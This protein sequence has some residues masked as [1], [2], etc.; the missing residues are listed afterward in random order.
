MCDLF[1]HNFLGR[2][3][4]PSSVHNLQLYKKAGFICKIITRLVQGYDINVFYAVLLGTTIPKILRF[5]V[6]A[7]SGVGFYTVW[8]YG[9]IS[10]FPRCKLPPLS[11][12]KF[13]ALL[14]LSTYPKR[15][16][17]YGKL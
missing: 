7:S 12:P 5:L 2:T 16:S 4:F 8:R 10:T 6:L 13:W 15:V 14:D 3:H 9:L 11:R 1:Y 17:K